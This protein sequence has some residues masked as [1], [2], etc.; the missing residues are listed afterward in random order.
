[1][2]EEGTARDGEV[3]A[4]GEPIH[5]P[6]PSYLPVIVA[7]GTTILLVG[8]VISPILVVIGLAITVVAIV[9]WIGQVR[10]EMAELP[11]EHDH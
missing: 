7:A 8:V 4:A 1:M 9:R 6:D 3:S 5:L 10:T 11:L 2:A